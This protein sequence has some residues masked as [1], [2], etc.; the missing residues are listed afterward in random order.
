MVSGLIPLK[1]T[2][3]LERTSVNTYFPRSTSFIIID[4]NRLSLCLIGHTSGDLH[5]R[6]VWKQREKHIKHASYQKRTYKDEQGTSCA[7]KVCALKIDTWYPFPI[8]VYIYRFVNTM[9]IYFC[10]DIFK[11]AIGYF[12]NKFWN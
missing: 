9:L 1:I 10:Y 2:E 11:Q 7:Y 12:S 8:N 6:D 4:S 3:L 5:K